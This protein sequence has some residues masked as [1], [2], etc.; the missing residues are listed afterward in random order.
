MENGFSG[1]AKAL[2]KDPTI[3]ELITNFSNLSTD[4]SKIYLNHNVIVESRWAHNTT[5]HNL[6]SIPD[7][8]ARSNVDKRNIVSETVQNKLA[9]KIGRK[10]GEINAEHY[11]LDYLKTIGNYDSIR[12]PLNLQFEFIPFGKTLDGLT[13]IAKENNIII[14]SYWGKLDPAF[15]RFGEIISAV[16]RIGKFGERITSKKAYLKELYQF[17]EYG[18]SALVFKRYMDADTEDLINDIFKVAKKTNGELSF[19]QGAF[20]EFL[21][22]H[23]GK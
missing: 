20:L 15:S 3:R 13:D 8:I 1:L 9:R 2:L 16:H 12:Q 14:I 22:K 4:L 21:R 11:F 19:Y 17:L 10:S 6:A 23:K 5:G 18:D 7:I